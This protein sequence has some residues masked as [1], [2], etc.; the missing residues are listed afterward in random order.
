VGREAGK[1]T[2]HWSLGKKIAQQQPFF[3][4][5]FGFWQLYIPVALTLSRLMPILENIYLLFLYR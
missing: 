3:L 2:Q 5:N 4:A 1:N